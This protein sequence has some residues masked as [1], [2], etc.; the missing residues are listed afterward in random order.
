MTNQP[1]V[2]IVTVCYNAATTIA[3]TINSIVGQ[4]YP[5]INYIIIDGNSTDNTM[6]IIAKYNNS[7]NTL[8]C[9]PDSGIYD[10]M[11]KSVKYFK[12]GWVLFIGAD[13]VLTSNTVIEQMSSYLKDAT[14]VYYGDSFFIKRKVKYD[15]HFSKYKLALRNISHQ[16]AFYPSDIFNHYTFNQ[17]YKLLADY[18]LNLQLFKHNNFC[19]KYVP[20]CI[21]NFNDNASSANNNDQQFEEDKPAIVKE[22]L[23]YGPYIYI[24]L[25]KILKKLLLYTNE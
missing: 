6:E 8:V 7:I 22:Y 12:K 5:Y 9:E 2:N 18:Y 3:T 1:I 15:G 23:G 4:T 21:T 11:N 16:S 13:D 14:T 17:K 10:A 25:R 24:R 20:I 19:F